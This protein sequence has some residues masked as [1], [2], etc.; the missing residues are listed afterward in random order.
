[1]ASVAENSHWPPKLSGINYEQK[2]KYTLREKCL[3]SELFWFAFSRIWTEYG[4]ILRISSYSVWMRENV[5]Q[6]NSK[7]GHVLHSDILLNHHDKKSHI[8]N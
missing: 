3:Y 5:Y 2:K 8:R 4:E 1:M 7:Y 6:N